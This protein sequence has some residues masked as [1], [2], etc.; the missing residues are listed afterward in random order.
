VTKVKRH[1]RLTL[2]LLAVAAMLII[3]WQIIVKTNENYRNDFIVPC[4][5]EN[6]RF[7]RE[8]TA[9][10]KER[11]LGVVECTNS[12][13]IEFDNMGEYYNIALTKT[14]Y[15]YHFY[16]YPLN[17]GNKYLFRKIKSKVD[18]SDRDV[19]LYKNK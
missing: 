9:D 2:F 5:I 8:V 10:N 7:L 11:T 17:D 15:L 16:V 3:P 6:T 1:Y 18:L 13:Y 12:I 4:V 14:P 19:T